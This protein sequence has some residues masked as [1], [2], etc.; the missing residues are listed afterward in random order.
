M[1]SHF[2]LSSF[3]LATLDFAF[4]ASYTDLWSKNYLSCVGGGLP[5]VG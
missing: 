3:F 2:S 4:N 5:G 1:S